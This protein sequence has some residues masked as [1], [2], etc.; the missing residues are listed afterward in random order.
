MGACCTPSYAN[1]YLGGWENHLMSDESLSMYRCHILSW[2]R[3]IYDILRLWNGSRDLL[4]TFIQ[5][6]NKND[7]SLSFTMT[8]YQK[9]IS[10]LDIEI[11]IKPNF[12]LGTTL[13]QK[14]KAGNTILKANS[15]HPSSLVK[16]IPYGQYLRIKWNCSSQEDFHKQANELKN[17]LL[18]RGY[19]KRTFKVYQWANT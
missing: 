5:L 14:P 12:T 3:Y 13:F 2:H 17:R 6:F 19:S 11:F 18:A 1:L 16:S 15:G 9:H 10:F 4:A 7:Y 8:S